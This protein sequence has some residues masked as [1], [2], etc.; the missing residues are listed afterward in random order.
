MGMRENE[1]RAASPA[2]VWYCG[3]GAGNAKSGRNEMPQLLR[4][5]IFAV[6]REDKVE[7]RMPKNGQ[8]DWV[9]LA[10]GEGYEAWLSAEQFKS[11]MSQGAEVLL[12]LTFENKDVAG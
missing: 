11:L 12:Q 3:S 8:T 1:L 5:K 4:E 7:V 9:H 10:F 2:T 6:R